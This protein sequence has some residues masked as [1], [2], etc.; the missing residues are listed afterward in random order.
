MEAKKK[1][2]KANTA[3]ASAIEGALDNADPIK[4]GLPNTASTS[5]PGLKEKFAAAFAEE[6][7]V[8]TK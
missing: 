2:A 4:G 7:F 5:A 6:N 3:I 1:T 8:I